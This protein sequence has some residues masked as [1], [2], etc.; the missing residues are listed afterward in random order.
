MREKIMA[1][2]SCIQPQ[3]ETPGDGNKSPNWSS[4]P[5]Q[6]P[7]KQMLSKS[8]TGYRK[9]GWL[10]I[11]P[12]LKA[13]LVHVNMSQK[14]KIQRTTSSPA[15]ASSSQQSGVDKIIRSMTSIQASAARREMLAGTLVAG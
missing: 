6:N 12:E 13:S 7:P 4:S 8:S 2:L 14:A 15:A 3:W 10:T 9:R 1:V 11:Y 5:D